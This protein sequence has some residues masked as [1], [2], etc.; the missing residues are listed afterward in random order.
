V[1]TPADTAADTRDATLLRTAGELADLP[2]GTILTTEGRV[3]IRAYNGQFRTSFGTYPPD[4][5]A[6]WY[7]PLRVLWRPDL[8]DQ[9]TLAARLAAVAAMADR[10]EHGATRW[11]DPLDVPE[12]IGELR[13]ILNGGSVPE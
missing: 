4:L 12:W 1:T 7:A 3:L 8:P 10:H 11:Q 2:D 6:R 13:A 5:L 9:T